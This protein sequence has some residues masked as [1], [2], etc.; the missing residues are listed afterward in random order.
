MQI[1]DCMIKCFRQLYREFHIIKW[2]GGDTFVSSLIKIKCYNTKLLVVEDESFLMFKQIFWTDCAVLHLESYIM[3]TNQPCYIS[4]DHEKSCFPWYDPFI[5]AHD[6]E[7]F[8]TI[9]WF[10][11]ILLTQRGRFIRL[12]LFPQN[13]T[14]SGR[15]GRPL[16]SCNFG[17]FWV[18]ASSVPLSVCII[19]DSARYSCVYLLALWGTIRPA[20]IL[21]VL[22]CKKT[23]TFPTK[24]YRNKSNRA[25]SSDQKQPLATLCFVCFVA[26]HCWC[27]S[28]T[29]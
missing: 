13:W 21:N 10:L 20:L 11:I 6:S 24:N 23:E 22:M 9:I 14:V 18:S 29:R 17:E 3:S 8:C 16:S 19:H 26:V 1:N 12:N 27:F 25:I 28:T 15:T 5:Q 2:E 7:I 4:R